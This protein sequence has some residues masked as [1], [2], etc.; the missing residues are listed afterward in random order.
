[1]FR[2]SEPRP[3]KTSPLPYAPEIYE[4]NLSN[5][6]AYIQN[7]AKEGHT[8]HR[9]P[10]QGNVYSAFWSPDRSKI[11]MAVAPSSLVDDSFMEQKILVVDHH[12]KEILAEVDHT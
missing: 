1:V 5:T 7:V 6:W 3:E 11:A 12:S 8:P 9:I 4:E 2:A 10:V